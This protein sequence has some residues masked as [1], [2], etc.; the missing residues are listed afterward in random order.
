MN[1]LISSYQNFISYKLHS[2]NESAT[3]CLCGRARGGVLGR[4]WVHPNSLILFPSLASFPCILVPSTE[5]TRRDARKPHEERGNEEISNEGIGMYPLLPVHFL[6]GA[7]NHSSRAWWDFQ[8]YGWVGLGERF[9]SI[10]CDPWENCDTV[11]NYTWDLT[12]NTGCRS[13]MCCHAEG[14]YLMYLIMI[15]QMI[16]I[17]CSNIS[18]L[19]IYQYCFEI[20]K[21][22][23]F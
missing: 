12:H 16:N 20:N 10:N 7:V 22:F 17:M 1:N 2:L 6:W 11:A 18:G 21:L 13:I 23:F 4:D 8:W 14:S 19:L 5:D 3:V 15:I 9:N